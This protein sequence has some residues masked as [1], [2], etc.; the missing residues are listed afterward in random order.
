MIPSST[1]CCGSSGIS[2]LFS[3][4]CYFPQAFKGHPRCIFVP[5]PTVLARVLN[6]S[7]ISIDSFL[8][9]FIICRPWTE[10][11]VFHCYAFLPGSCG[12]VLARP[13]LSFGMQA[14]YSRTS[15][16]LGGLCC[17]LMLVI[18]LAARRRDGV[19]SQGGQ[20]LSCKAKASVFKLSSARVGER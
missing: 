10:Y 9:N 16:S 18:V 15:T 11:P 2:T 8:S 6:H 12:C 4:S 5:S 1:V 19:R 17:D 7:P 20:V 13:C 3:V 14:S